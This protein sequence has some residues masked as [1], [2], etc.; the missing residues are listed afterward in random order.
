VSRRVSALQTSIT[1]IIIEPAVTGAVLLTAWMLWRTV[2][3]AVV[4]T[5]STNCYWYHRSFEG[6]LSSR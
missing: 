3:S 1:I 2:I 5:T 4:M 6:G